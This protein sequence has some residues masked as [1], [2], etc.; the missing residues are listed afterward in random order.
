[1][2]SI[3]IYAKIIAMRIERERILFQA[4]EFGIHYV[5]FLALALVT[6]YAAYEKYPRVGQQEQLPWFLIAAA[7]CIIG[8][9]ADKTVSIRTS[10]TLSEADQLGIKHNVVEGN[11]FLP[12][13]PTTR[14]FLLSRKTPL[15][16]GAGIAGVFYPPLGIALGVSR[17][18]VAAK[19]EFFINR[20]I[21]RQISE[22]GSNRKV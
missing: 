4:R 18:A 8:T 19:N 17:L 14:E 16:V 13:R 6:F 21:R 12:D 22:I 11:P 15:E 20:S 5:P 9:V 7:A 10:H 2:T 3:R 1:M